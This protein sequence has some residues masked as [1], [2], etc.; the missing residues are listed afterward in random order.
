MLLTWQTFVL[1]ENVK[2]L[3][4]MEQKR[5]FLA[6]QLQY[7]NMMRQ[8]Q[9]ILENANANSNSNASGAGGGGPMR[10]DLMITFFCID[11]YGDGWSGSSVFSQG[12]CSLIHPTKGIVDVGFDNSNGTK[13]P[14]QT[15]ANFPTGTPTGGAIPGFSGNP[16]NVVYPV[17]IIEKNIPYPT[18]Q[19]GIQVITQNNYAQENRLIVSA[20]WS[21]Y[22]NRSQLPTTKPVIG[23]G[24]TGI[25]PYVEN[26][27]I[28]NFQAS[29]T[30]NFSYTIPKFKGGSSGTSDYTGNQ[31]WIRNVV[32]L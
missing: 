1:Q 19:Y 16:T 18:Q 21:P 32:N 7:E 2:N 24:S 27:L 9:M 14:W 6:H 4:L 3:P 17:T 30:Y 12:T 23:A 8:K 29:T 13:P 5:M 25:Q 20:G 28:T 26:V 31:A 15:I 10:G 11:T 22:P